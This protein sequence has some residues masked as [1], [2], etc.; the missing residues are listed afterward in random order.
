MPNS[1]SSKKRHRQSVDRRAHNRG[2]KSA[3]KT[4]I[5]K[6]KEAVESGD[7]KTSSEELK[8]AAKKLDQAAS[9]GVIHKNTSSRLKS[10]L[11]AHVKANVKK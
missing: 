4:Q 8:A 2:I 5:R 11:S 1:A 7:A 3:L 6:L 9:K 10:R